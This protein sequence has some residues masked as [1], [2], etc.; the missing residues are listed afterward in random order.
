MLLGRK[1][2]GIPCEIFYFNDPGCPKMGGLAGV[3]AGALYSE[4]T[5]SELSLPVT[6]LVAL[7]SGVGFTWKRVRIVS[8]SP[9][10]MAAGFVVWVGSCD[11]RL[12]ISL[13]T[14]IVVVLMPDDFRLA[15]PWVGSPAAKTT[16]ESVVP[17]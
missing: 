15:E 14:E 7:N 6:S 2:Q 10:W 3:L 4:F 8:N 12:P 17:S 16:F 13:G 9:G 11:K 5:L 1:Y